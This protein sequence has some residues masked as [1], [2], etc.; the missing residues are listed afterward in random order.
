M[1]VEGVV[2]AVELLMVAEPLAVEELF[3]V[4]ELL[5]TMELLAEDELAD[6]LKYSEV[7][8]VFAVENPHPR[9]KVFEKSML[10]PYV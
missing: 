1:S 5:V 7:N 4:V 8:P 9:K 3:A 6:I 2:E 10:K